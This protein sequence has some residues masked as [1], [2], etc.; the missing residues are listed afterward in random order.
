[1]SE[2]KR[3]DPASVPEKFKALGVTPQR[4]LFICV[5]DINVPSEFTSSGTC[6]ACACGIDLIETVGFDEAH[7]TI[8]EW[9]NAADSGWIFDILE[10]KTGRHAGYLEGLSGGWEGSRRGRFSSNEATDAGW[11]DG[12][13]AW[14]ACVEAGIAV[15]PN[16]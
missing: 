14:D 1:M 13:A 9:E 7:A 3:I 4:G 16:A 5:P 12:N 15:D 6:L 11:E 10:S 2:L 8:R